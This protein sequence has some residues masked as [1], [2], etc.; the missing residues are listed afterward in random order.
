MFSLG[1]LARF[2]HAFVSA[3][4]RSLNCRT[5]TFYVA[6]TKPAVAS[7]QCSASFSQFLELRRF[8]SLPCLA[9]FL[10]IRKFPPEG[11]PLGYSFIEIPT[12]DTL[13]VESGRHTEQR[14]FFDTNVR[15]V[16]KLQFPAL[17]SGQRQKVLDFFLARKGSLEKFTLVHP[18]TGELIV[19]R[20]FNTTQEYELMS[21]NLY[22]TNQV[23]L[24]E[25][26]ESF[27]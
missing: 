8:P 20:F 7:L 4:L 14:A 16:F 1:C 15:W 11:V 12:F 2:T 26:E 18:L 19:V 21:H 23:I 24:V 25:L 22:R 17:T 6:E 9:R 5:G 27:T 13:L 10:D 3:P